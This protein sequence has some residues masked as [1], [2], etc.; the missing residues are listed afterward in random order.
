MLFD[1]A[2]T[3]TDAISHYHIIK[4]HNFAINLAQ[5]SILQNQQNKQI[6]RYIY[7]NIVCNLI[8]MVNGRNLCT[9]TRKKKEM[10]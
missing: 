7:M 1:A 6:N 10:L 4:N 8:C 5:C 2:V 9:A 3:V